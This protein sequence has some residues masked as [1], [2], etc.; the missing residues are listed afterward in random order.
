MSDHLRKHPNINF[1]FLYGS[2]MA[3]GA[4]WLWPSP[5]D[6]I[7]QYVLAGV[8]VVSA[9][10]GFSNALAGLR[11]DYF[12]RVR[13]AAANTP[14]GAH[15]SGRFAALAEL[16]RA[17]FLNP[18]GTLLLGLHKV[19]APVFLPPGLMLAVQSPP[20]GGKTSS[21]VIGAI[22]H[23][24]M[25][26]QSVIVT[27]VKP[28]MVYLWADRLRRMGFR[29]FVNNPGKVGGLPHDGDMN[30]FRILVEI[31]ADP[32]R[33]G[34]AFVQ[35]ETFA[36]VL[37]R[38]V[39]GDK[40][41]GYFKQIDRMHFQ[42]AALA[43][44]VFEPQ[45]CTPSGVQRVLADPRAF[46]NLMFEA[47]R[48]DVL[49]GDLS[50]LA[51]SLIA[52]AKDNPEH[53]DGGLTGAA[54]ALAAFKPSS[55]LGRVGLDDV[56]HPADLRRTDLPPA[57]IFDVMP[58]DHAEVFAKAHALQM[59]ARLAGLKRHREGRKVLLLCDEATNFPVPTIVSDIELM[60]SFGIT[61]ALFFQ[62]YS[63][64]ERVYGKD[65]AASIR[66]SSV[67]VYFGV[68]DLATAEEISRRAGEMTIKTRS[69]GFGEDGASSVNISE[70]GRRV[71]PP[72]DILALDKSAM[73]VLAPGM[74][75]ILLS[76]APWFEVEP[77]KSLADG[78][79]PHERHPRSPVTRL[80]LRY[81]K[82]AQE[83]GAPVVPGL[84]ALLKAAFK[85]EARA[86]RRKFVPL[87]TP[88]ALFWVPVVAFAAFT[89]ATR[90][91]PHVLFGY[92]AASGLGGGNR[93]LYFGADGLRVL[94][95]PGTCPFVRL[96]H[97]DTE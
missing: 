12:R 4:R 1:W 65:Q 45:Q 46:K 20:G 59:T 67:E 28:E 74:R 81:G 3:A 61:V 85:A 56:I 38:D 19:G 21:L 79:N 17:H 63:S 80:A 27:D 88:R 50:A 97:P 7:G 72:E 52:K 82:D 73:I 57:I 2:S 83:I 96:L 60:R 22:F 23:A 29:I 77:Y 11:L 92:Q 48:S 9:A 42:A 69:H 10:V 43:L 44:A 32:A 36:Q 66:A 40:N 78:V 51:R 70:V 16:L 49:S 84:R 25:T 47:A 41:G 68:G 53:A 71:L 6:Y 26:G 13:I 35:A 30:P 8:L 87:V 5:G 37:I 89:L 93:C 54:N 90:G 64:L 86:Q 15:G 31:M 62:S 39:E 94:E 76:R 33:H 18:A 75:P 91:E 58:A 95:T 34:E 14:S 24:L 55:F